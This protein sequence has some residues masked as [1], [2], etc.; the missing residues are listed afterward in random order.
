M[1]WYFNVTKENFSW[2]LR[3]YILVSY[4]QKCLL[5]HEK[6][7]YI[8][9]AV[10][11]SQVS[12]IAVL[13]SLLFS[14][15]YVCLYQ[16][17]NA[18]TFPVTFLPSFFSFLCKSFFLNKS[19]NEKVNFIYCVLVKKQRHQMLVILLFIFENISYSLQHCSV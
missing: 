18:S 14:R 11:N 4:E 2:V 13:F 15:K 19:L 16:W 17:C 8:S 12:A 5:I 10:T 9:E 6:T 3:N 1:S 7:M